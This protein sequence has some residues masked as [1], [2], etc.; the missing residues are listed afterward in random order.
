LRDAFPDAA[1]DTLGYENR[2]TAPRPG[3]HHVDWDLTEAGHG[4]PPELGGYG[5]IVLA[6]VIEHLAVSP[7]ALLRRLAAW[8]L[9][10]GVLV[11]QTPNALALH[12]RLRALAGRDPLG[13][14]G[15]LT[16]PSHNPGH[17]REY[18]LSELIEVA[19]AAG[20]DPIDSSV[21]N[22]FRHPGAV[23]RAYDALTSALPSGTRQGITLYL[24]WR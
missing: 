14:G 24:R 22:Y 13:A 17:F 18:T 1:V 16:G 21:R 12:K 9:A 6:E 2:L 5:L 11:I 23:A 3:E 4:E 10:D 15:R 20:F 8:L 19:A 7:V